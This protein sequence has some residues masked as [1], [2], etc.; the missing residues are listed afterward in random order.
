MDD[1][2]MRQI[3]MF[4]TVAK[5]Q[6]ISKAAQEL[7][8][9]QPAASN[10]IAKIEE[11]CG[12]RLFNRTNRG[13]E[14]TLEGEELYARLDVAYHRFRVSVEEICKTNTK[15]PSTLHIGVLN[16]QHVMAVAEEQIHAFS[17]QYPDVPVLSERFNFHELRDKILCEELDVIFSLSADINPYP[18]FDSIPICDFHA[19]FLVPEGWEKTLVT[20]PDFCAL[21]GKT[22]II[23]VP[24]QRSWAESICADYDIVPSDVRYV[25]SYIL[26]SALV[27]HGQGFSI[28]GKMIT[29][30]I[31]APMMASLPVTKAHTSKIVM[32]W[33]KEKRSPIAEKYIEC[34]GGVRFG[35]MCSGEK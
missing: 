10:A 29:E 20:Q 3:E 23:E 25:N 28:D 22:M 35:D 24:T 32:A 1:I 7:Y 9:S 34:I 26:L 4:L 31:Y 19:F 14:L 16:R 11:Y 12:F 13:V 6:N 27:S 33:K 21:S 8:T 2:N 5:Y 18:E 30:G 15:D 17:L